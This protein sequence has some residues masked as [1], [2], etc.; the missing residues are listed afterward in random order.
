MTTT[1]PGRQADLFAGQT[2]LFSAPGRKP[3]WE[4]HP[5]QADRV[6]GELQATLEQLRETDVFP[7]RDGTAA[8][9]AEIRFNDLAEIWLPPEEGHPL[10]LAFAVEMERLGRAVDYPVYDWIGRNRPPPR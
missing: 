9:S 5:G 3:A 1:R 10:Q 7:F 2:D 6:R 8:M 4:E